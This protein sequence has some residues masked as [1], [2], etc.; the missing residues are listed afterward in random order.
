MISAVAADTW[1]RLKACPDCRWVFYDHSRNGGKRWCLMY[2]GGP[3]NRACAGTM[4]AAELKKIAG[5]CWTAAAPRPSICGGFVH[6]LLRQAG[7]Q[8]PPQ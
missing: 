6:V 4:L 7:R 5:S 8:G 2:A 3:A 1:R